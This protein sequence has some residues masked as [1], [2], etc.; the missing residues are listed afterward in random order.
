MENFNINE[1]YVILYALFIISFFVL[2]VLM[3]FFVFGI[4][5]QSKRTNKLLE[6]LID[7]IS[8]QQKNDL[9]KNLNSQ[10]INEDGNQENRN[11]EDNVAI[12]NRCG[13]E[14]RYNSKNHS[15]HIVCSHCDCVVDLP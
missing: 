6:N 2:L 13:E 8:I 14:V 12:C 9:E 7:N 15:D 11:Q 5:Q 1:I 4:Y 3:P 10:E